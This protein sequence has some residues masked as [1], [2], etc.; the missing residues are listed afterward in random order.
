[1]YAIL[2]RVRDELMRTREEKKQVFGAAIMSWCSFGDKVVLYKRDGRKSPVTRLAVTTYM[3]E[4]D[5]VSL[6]KGT[7]LHA[8]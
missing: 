2:S 4:I 8:T 1:L 3:A 7:T 6:V 5:I